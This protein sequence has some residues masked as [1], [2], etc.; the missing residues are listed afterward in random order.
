MTA[1]IF[2]EQ[3]GRPRLNLLLIL[4]HDVW[5][6][7]LQSLGERHILVLEQVCKG[8]KPQLRTQPASL[9]CR[10]YIVYEQ[11]ELLLVR[12]HSEFKEL[13]EEQ[14]VRGAIS[15]TGYLAMRRLV[16]QAHTEG[17]RYI[18][19]SRKF[20][21]VYESCM[22]PTRLAGVARRQEQHE[23]ALKHMMAT[24]QAHLDVARTQT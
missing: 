9:D 10:L 17:Q 20:V 11:H 1:T 4:P 6:E 14:A 23:R 7:V 2:Q 19:M 8:L 5:T 15:R 21:S 12:V 22:S 18:R 16:G 24:A 13:C 3:H